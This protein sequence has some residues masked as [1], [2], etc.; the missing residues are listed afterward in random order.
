MQNV[1]LQPEDT[2][3]GL[4]ISQL[5]LAIWIGRVDEQGNGGRPWY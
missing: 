1:E 2:G 4:Q 3:G 5:G